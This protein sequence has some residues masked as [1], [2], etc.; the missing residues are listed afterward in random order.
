MADP[1]KAYFDALKTLDI[2]HATEHTLRGPLENLLKAL[3]AQE[4]PKIN[5]I[6][7]PK[8]DKTGLGAPDFMFKLN[9]A[10]LGYLENKKI[11]ED[12]DA[13]LKSEQIAKYKQLSGNI[14]LTNYLEWVWLKDGHINK[15]E[16]LC[17]GSVRYPAKGLGGSRVANGTASGT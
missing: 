11:G 16:T 17:Y 5:V 4:N 6:H 8:K 9:E 2:H 14:I 3:V 10:A 15:R 12:L 7:E 13:I 1:F